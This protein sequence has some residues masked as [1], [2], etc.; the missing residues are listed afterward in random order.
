[1][2]LRLPLTFI[3]L[4]GIAGCASMRST[5]AAS[6]ST[7]GL[8]DTSPLII[9]DSFTIDSRVMGEA[10][11][12]NVLVPTVYGEKIEAA[13]PVLYM[14]D[15]GV[16]EDFLHI[17]GL[18]QLLVSNGSM[19]PFMLVGIENTSRRRDLTGPTSSDADR[20][21][22]PVVGGS[23]TFR[24]FIRAELMPAIRGRY[25]TTAEAA[26][27]GE[28][29]AGLFVVETLLLEPDLFDTYIAVDP[30][31]WWSDEALLK[32]AADRLCAAPA[33]HRALFLAHSNEPELSRLAARMAAIVK[34]N[35]GDRI[36]F[37]SQAFPDEQHAT[38]YHPAA[39][40]AFRMVLAPK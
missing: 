21:I 20:K 37:L 10:R 28:S 36:E 6:P 31:L 24:R 19:R 1:M 18:V 30:S 8:A 15:G 35:R 22:A 23:A 12:V 2:I 17:A 3:T 25:R 5:G 34:S 11:R 39:L 14:L 38:I 32:S 26:I 9:G 7:Q 27:V 13:L 16:H 40:A 33:G 29:L 4:A